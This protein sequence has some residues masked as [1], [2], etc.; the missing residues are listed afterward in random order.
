LRGKLVEFLFFKNNDIAHDMIFR[1]R[2]T[3][4]FL[5]LI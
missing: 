3:T 4:N 1:A 5:S 2:C